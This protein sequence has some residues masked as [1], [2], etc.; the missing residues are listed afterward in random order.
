ML[1]QVVVAP[2]V[3]LFSIG[4][5]SYFYKVEY[6]LITLAFLAVLL[7]M[8]FLTG[9][10]IKKLKRTEAKYT[11]ERLKLI[12]DMVTGVRTIKCYAWENHYLEKITSARNK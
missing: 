5:I 9:T 11:D 6:G 3:S 4:L 7:V 2:I 1:P 12:T 8:Q 10:G